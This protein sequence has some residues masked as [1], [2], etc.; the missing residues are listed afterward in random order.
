MNITQEG[1]EMYISRNTLVHGLQ[2][3]GIL[4]LTDMIELLKMFPEGK[5]LPPDYAEL[6]EKTFKEQLRKEPYQI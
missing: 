2:Q 5:P 1:E 3:S 4:S 6:L